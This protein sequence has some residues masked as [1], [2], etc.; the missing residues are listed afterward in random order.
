MAR[1]WFEAGWRRDG[2]EKRRTR[3]KEERTRADEEGD[4]REVS[5]SACLLS[6]LPFPVLSILI[7]CLNLSLSPFF[8]S[9]EGGK[10]EG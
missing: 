9:A 10:M 8:I 6:F 4:N 2:A 3:T 5:L 1:D 7:V